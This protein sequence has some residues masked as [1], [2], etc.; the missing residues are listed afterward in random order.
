MNVYLRIEKAI[1]LREQKYNCAQTVV[2]AYS[3]AI[4]VPFGELMK[5]TEG[6]GGG[7]AG[8]GDICGALSGAALVLG[9]LKGTSVADV[10][11][12]EALNEQIKALINEFKEEHGTVDC[13]EL[14]GVVNPEVR[15]KE[16]TCNELIF[17]VI[18]LIDKHL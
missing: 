11:H 2:G 7:V 15:K 6:L 16:A 18:R 13:F 9:F 3:D 10:A 12:K 8:T 1:E 17:N 5:M 4:E 14:K